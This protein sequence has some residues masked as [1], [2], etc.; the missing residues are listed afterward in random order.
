MSRAAHQLTRIMTQTRS[1]FSSVPYMEGH[2]A[3][4]ETCATV[5]KHGKTFI[6]TTPW[7]FDTALYPLRLSV[8]DY[9]LPLVELWPLE[10]FLTTHCSS[11]V[12]MKSAATTLT[13]ALMVKTSAQ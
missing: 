9:F 12:Q 13:L 11:L 3:T 7:L 6:Y 4:G 5:F 10:I 8:Y 1:I 2:P